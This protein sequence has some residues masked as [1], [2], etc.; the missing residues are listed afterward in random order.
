MKY[1]ALL[2][3]INLGATHKVPMVELRKCFETVGFT[4]VKTLL[5]SGNVLF[6]SDAND[7]E[8]LRKKIEE[9]LEERFGFSIGTIVRPQQELQE[10]VEG[11]P[12]R[13]I[14]V[15]PQTRLYVTFLSEE[16]NGSLKIPYES[17]EKNFKILEVL[18]KAIF[19]VVI[20]SEKYG[21]LDAMNIIGKE[22]SKNVTTRNWNTVVKMAAL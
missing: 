20:L 3:G 4:A 18:G 7:I 5:N 19:S 16:P 22:Y 6:S 10:M 11:N 1:I 15:T 8:T 17:Q 2:R 12:F 21:T 9:C 14:E 13:K